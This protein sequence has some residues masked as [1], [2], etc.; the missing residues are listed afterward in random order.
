MADS[1]TRR[2]EVNWTRLWV[3]TAEEG[4]AVVLVHAGIADARMWDDQWSWL[5]AE[6]QVVRY[7]LLGFGHSARSVGPFAHDHDLLAL[8]DALACAPSRD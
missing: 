2:V 3:E 7:D 4:P 8:M 1:H 6:H 5:A